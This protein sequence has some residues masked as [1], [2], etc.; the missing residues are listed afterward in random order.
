MRLLDKEEK[1]RYIEIMKSI[2][3]KR[4]KVPVKKNPFGNDDKW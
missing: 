3:W 1:L 2:E 4:L